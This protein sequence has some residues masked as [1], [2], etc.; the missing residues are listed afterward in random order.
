MK[1]TV[2]WWIL[3][4]L[5]TVFSMVLIVMV[6]AAYAQ[7]YAA[8]SSTPGTSGI[9]YFGV[10]WGYAFY[11]L[12]PAAAVHLPGVVCAI[13]GAVCTDRRWERWAFAVWAAAFVVTVPAVVLSLA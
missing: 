5:L 11:Y 10:G 4:G 6:H 1:R 13:A 8:L 12:L 9:D 2:I 3:C 7:E